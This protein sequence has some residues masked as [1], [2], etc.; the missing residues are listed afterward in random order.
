MCYSMSNLSRLSDALFLFRSSTVVC[1]HLISEDKMLQ[2]F[3]V[4]KEEFFNSFP[5]FCLINLIISRCS[6]HHNNFIPITSLSQ[7]HHYPN[8]III[9]V[10]FSWFP[11]PP[12][13]P[14]VGGNWKI[15]FIPASELRPLEM[16]LKGGGGKG[17]ATSGPSRGAMKGLI[18]ALRNLF[19]LEIMA[20]R[21][22]LCK[23]VLHR[24]SRDLFSSSG[25]GFYFLCD[26][27]FF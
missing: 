3:L 4:P 2:L 18:R 12:C 11:P 24:R 25:T 19:F 20:N 10:Y 5:L 9:P 16:R 21:K 15:L 27:K 22:T 23:A 7:S 26:F 6:N 14:L 17:S 1:L 8:H 13:F